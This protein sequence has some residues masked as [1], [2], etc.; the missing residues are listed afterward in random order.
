MISPRHLLLAGGGGAANTGV[1]NGFQIFQIS[2]NGEN[3]VGDSVTRI[4]T[5]EY[6]VYS[7][8][9]RSSASNNNLPPKVTLIAGHNQFAQLYT[10]S[11][12]RELIGSDNPVS[13]GDTLRH[14]SQNGVPGGA[15]V[16]D[17]SG[18]SDHRLVF[19]CEPGTKVQIDYNEKEPY[20]K[21]LRLSLNGKLMAS[22]GDDGHLR[23]WSFPNLSL[24]HDF[25][26]HDR[27][28]DDLDFSTD[29]NKLASVS[30][31]KRCIV[32]DVRKGK[33]HAELCWDS[34]VNTK[35]MYKRCKFGCVE[36][37]L[38]KFKVFTI[39]NPIGNSKAPAFLHRWNTQT[40]TVE[41]SVSSPGQ[42]YSALAVSDCGTFV[43]CG[44]MSEG[45]VDIH[46]AYNLNRVKRVKGAHSTFITGLEFLPTSDEAAPS[47][48]FHEASV[49][50]IS[51]D[52]QVCVT[53]VEGQATLS[54]FV[55]SL[56]VVLV[57]LATFMLAS[58]L[59]L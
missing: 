56:L 17:T 19:K 57:L 8:A 39:S 3:V 21:V 33:K 2:S 25:T 9:A 7:I 23:V 32:W 51:V 13:G 41:G 59:G 54:S 43:A 14:R 16:Q 44:S 38:K 10:L 55:A 49:V 22:G 20:G 47:R 6:C 42:C 48:G 5:G 36:G 26:S 52:H 18:L 37:D 28:I 46:T 58:Y 53:H 4:F 15:G 11:L 34:P 31:D 24:V 12:E 50:S 45:I 40:F 30:K 1:K 27:E 35:Y 29:S